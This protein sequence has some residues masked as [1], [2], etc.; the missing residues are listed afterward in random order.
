MFVQRLER[1]AK[2]PGEACADVVGKE[3]ITLKLAVCK[4]TWG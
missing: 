3:T 1:N 4:I 2:F